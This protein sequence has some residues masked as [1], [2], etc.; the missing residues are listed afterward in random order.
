MIRACL[1]LLA[2]AYALHFTSFVSESDLIIGALFGALLLYGICG[3]ITAL[4][5][6]GGVLLFVVHARTV[7]AERVEHRFEGD[8]MLVVVA[9]TELPVL[10]GDSYIL[11][12]SPLDDARIPERVRLSWHRTNQRP[13]VGDVWQF[14]VRLKYP[15]GLMNPGG[16][17]FE[18]WLFRSRFGATGYIVSGSRNKRLAQDTG[19]RLT[20]FRRDHAERLSATIPN[21]DS[22][23]VVA[24]I[25]V[26]ARHLLTPEQWRR[27]SPASRAA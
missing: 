13:R 19:S 14:E 16:F 10:R 5:F 25:S 12:V 18:A 1:G 15:R 22:A 7:I 9:V 26:G 6:L 23:A 21:A 8:S 24:A 3:R 27:E 20:R 4:L 2:G 11:V 17:D